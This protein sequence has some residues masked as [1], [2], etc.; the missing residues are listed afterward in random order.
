MNPSR[1]MV[2]SS[3]AA[4]LVALAGPAQ[5]QSSDA[6]R[7][8]ELEQKLERSLELINQ[9]SSKIDR[10][11]QAAAKARDSQAA[12][13]QQE[14]KIEAIEKHVA[15]IGG[16]LARRPTDLGLPVHGFADVG[17][18]R[19]G[20][21]NPTAT[22]RKGAA[23]GTSLGAVDL[24][25]TPRFGDRVKT[26]IELV[27]EAE[28]NGKTAADLERVQIG[29]A[30]SD[31][32]TAWLGRFHTPY[33]YWNTAYHH[34]AQIQTSVLRPRFLDFEHDGGI[35]PAHTTGAWLTGSL[36][37]ERGRVG[38]DL[39][40]GNA[41]Q[42]NGVTA[43]S[44][45][46]AAYRTGFST[47]VNAGTYAGSGNLDVRHAGSTTQRSSIGFNA[48]FEPHAADGLRV[49]LH[50]L[51]AKVVDDAALPNQ[52][53][54]KMLGG[55]FA[56]SIEPWETLAEYYRFRNDDRSGASGAHGSWA[57][58]A[59][60]AYNMRQWTPFARIERSRLDQTDN[61]FGVQ[62]SGRSYQRL[63]AGLRFD[64][65]P[66]AALKVEFASTRKEDLGPQSVD[67]F[68]EFHLQYAIRF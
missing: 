43:G 37:T 44:N 48:W 67:K 31:A 52:T 68:P 18:T 53:L 24:Y 26:L 1:R 4:L 59:Q 11:E 3:A 27:F 20:E 22:G 56:Y 6:A 5:A 23:L 41:P 33:G 58:Y 47:A 60:I 49:G 61:Y 17:L 2:T 30:F 63:A 39:F 25:L 14:A 38:Y 16:S 62:A 51:R 34:G 54:V 19:N 64:I 9:L 50:G 36:K 28:Q 42:I 32:A 10:I 12:T 13:S 55:Y 46:A 66:N 21:D 8:K 40:A 57:G 45:L 35:L 65:D 7:I 29:Y 15:E